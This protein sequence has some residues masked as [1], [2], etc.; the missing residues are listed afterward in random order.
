M[1][2]GNGYIMVSENREDTGTFFGDKEGAIMND[3]VTVQK[4]FRKIPMFD[5]QAVCFEIDNNPSSAG[6]LWSVSKTNL[7]KRELVCALHVLR[8]F[9]KY[10]FYNLYVIYNCL[11]LI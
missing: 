6:I 9:M 7:V 3:M 1:I 4:I 10:M 8:N 11:L 5:Y 2:D